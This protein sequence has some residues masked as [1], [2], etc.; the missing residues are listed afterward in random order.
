MSRVGDRCRWQVGDVLRGTACLEIAI[1]VAKRTTALK[2]P[3]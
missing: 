1:G 3:T 2:F